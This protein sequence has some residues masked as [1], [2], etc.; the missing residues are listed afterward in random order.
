MRAATSKVAAAAAAL[1][2][3]HALPQVAA[4]AVLQVPK[5]RQLLVPQE[6]QTC[7]IGGGPAGIMSRGGGYPGKDYPKSHGL[8]GSP[9][10]NAKQP[11]FKGSPYMKKGA[12]QA[13]YTAGDTVTFEI[14]INAWHQ[15]H[16]EFRICETGIH[17]GIESPEAGQECLNKWLLKRAP[18][19]SGCSVGNDFD[20]QPIHPNYPERW[21]QSPQNGNLVNTKYDGGNPATWKDEYAMDQALQNSLGLGPGLSLEQEG[22]NRTQSINRVEKMRYIIP[23]DLSCESC[24]LQWYWTSGNNCHYDTGDTAILALL[25]KEGWNVGAWSYIGTSGAIC[26]KTKFGEE[27]WNCADIV[28]KPK[29]GGG[30]GTRR[31]KETGETRR[32]KETG[33]TRRRK[34]TGETRRR[35]ETS[36]RRKS[37][38]RRRRRSSRRRD[39]TRRRT[40]EVRRRRRISRRR[41]SQRRRR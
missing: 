5:S 8:C 23:E 36:R 34:E 24:T 11:L 4:H 1:V 33:E 29:A 37:E 15:G 41:A 39:A 21:M 7:S 30:G 19:K 38:E 9:D 28:V 12:S 18:I 27:Y 20:C 16:Y 6:C 22:S 3:F 31:R 26:S 17:E 2:L 13:T 32:R 10:H 14:G 40:P 25:G 35:K